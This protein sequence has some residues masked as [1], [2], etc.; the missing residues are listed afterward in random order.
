MIW[1]LARESSMIGS[2]SLNTGVQNTVIA[3]PKEIS[4][5]LLRRE[6]LLKI[7]RV[8]DLVGLSRATI[9]RMIQENTFPHPV[10]L[11]ARRVGWARSEVFK[12]MGERILERKA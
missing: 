11:S 6:K 9:Y 10:K 4:P 2:N 8:T 12:W 7:R 5:L 3:Q 1:R